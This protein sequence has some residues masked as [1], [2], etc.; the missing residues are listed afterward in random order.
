MNNIQRVFTLNWLNM[1]DNRPFLQPKIK[2]SYD[3]S[4]DHST[5][6]T[7]RI[8]TE[9]LQFAVSLQGEWSDATAGGLLHFVTFWPS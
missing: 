3:L 8:L 1:I 6:V 7:F 5:V 4:K 2:I 9:C